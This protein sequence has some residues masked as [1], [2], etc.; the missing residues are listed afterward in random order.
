MLEA[1]RALIA[2]ILN[3]VEQYADYAVNFQL[4]R[5]E[6]GRLPML[7]V[8]FPLISRPEVSGLMRDVDLMNGINGD[9]LLFVKMYDCWGYR[10]KTTIG[11]RTMIGLTDSDGDNSVSHGSKVLRRVWTRKHTYS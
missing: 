5:V 8:L 2:E 4:V 9:E 7:S 1:L 3:K 6:R 10:C 11:R